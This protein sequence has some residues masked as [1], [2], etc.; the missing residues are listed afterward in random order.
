MSSRCLVRPAINPNSHVPK[1][2]QLKARFMR[3]IQEGRWPEGERFASDQELTS[4]LGVSRMTVRQAVAEMVRDGFLRR[5]HGRGTFVTRPRALRRFWTVIS[6]TEEMRSR[7]LEV[8]N[9]L[10]GVR[11]VIPS[12]RIRKALRLRP[13]ERVLQI[14][15]IRAVHGQPIAY[16]VSNIPLSR[17][18]DLDSAD[19]EEDSLYIIIQN[20]YGYRIKHGDRAYRAAR[21]SRAEAALLGI[22]PGEQVL[23]VE[24]TTFVDREVPIDYCYEVYRE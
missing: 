13:G 9:R 11:R 22:A 21:P 15:R 24:G 4:Q 6:F 1:Y 19:L 14:R 17:C 23:I 10:L 3:E 2:L 20:R 5:D 16:N 12:G 8:Q 7:G 18:P